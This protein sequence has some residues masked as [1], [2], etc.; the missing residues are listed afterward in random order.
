LASARQPPQGLAWLAMTLAVAAV[1]RA[2]LGRGEIK[3]GMLVGLALGLCV[4]ATVAAHKHRF[5]VLVASVG[6]ALSRLGLFAQTPSASSNP[7]VPRFAILGNYPRL[8]RQTLADRHYENRCALQ[9]IREHPISRLGR[10]PTT[11]RCS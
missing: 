1:V 5:A 7:I 2:V 10:G 9:Q 11:A 3:A 8:K 6:E 4:A